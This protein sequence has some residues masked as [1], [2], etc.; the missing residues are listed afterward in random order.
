MR[1]EL[2]Q[3]TGRRDGTAA[4]IKALE[5]RVGELTSAA[6]DAEA[7][8]DQIFAPTRARSRRR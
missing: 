2:T 1:E 8:L 6:G 7:K 3:L 4:E 5:H